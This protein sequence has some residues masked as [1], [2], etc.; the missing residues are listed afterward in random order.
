MDEYFEDPYNSEIGSNPYNGN[1]LLEENP[2]GNRK[3]GK[4]HQKHHAQEGRGRSTGL[5]NT[6]A[7]LMDNYYLVESEKFQKF[8]LGK[9]QK[10]SD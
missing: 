8:G 2:L 7:G 4:K 10:G 9:R 3:L 1:D 6:N 5:G